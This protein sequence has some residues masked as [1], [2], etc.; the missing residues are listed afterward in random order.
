MPLRYHDPFWIIIKL[1]L[2]SPAPPSESTGT[3]LVKYSWPP[4][5]SKKEI[6]VGPIQEFEAADKLYQSLFN[7]GSGK[8]KLSIFVTYVGLMHF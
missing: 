1:N 5:P 7:K 8:M 2:Y 3:L 6:I 4:P